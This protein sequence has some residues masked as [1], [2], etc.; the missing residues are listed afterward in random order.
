MVDRASS[1]RFEPQVVPLEDLSQRI[2]AKRQREGLTLGRAAQQ[3]GVSAATL[4]RLERRCD[5]TSTEAGKSASIPDMRTIA[6]VARWLGVALEQVVA[7][8]PPPLV[9][10]VAHRV[11]DTV[12]EMVEAHLRADR[13]L[14]AATAVALARTFRAAYEQ[15]SRLSTASGRHDDMAT[16]EEVEGRKQ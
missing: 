12:P 5:A 8:D 14:D 15:F 11:G 7:V 2:R 1:T 9:T 6:A 3:S 16:A 10:D 13:N 4:S